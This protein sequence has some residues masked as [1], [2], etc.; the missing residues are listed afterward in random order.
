MVK[1]FDDLEKIALGRAKK[2]RVLVAAAHDLHTLEGIRDASAKG[3]VDPILIGDAARIRE[4]ISE[5]GLAL[6]HAAIID[7]KDDSACARIAA[8][9]VSNGAGDV[10]M[11]GKLQTP[12]L[13]RE[14]VNKAYGLMQGEI[15]SHVGLFS[16][17]AYHKLF[18]LTDG[19]M[20]IAPDAEE[21]RKI[22]ANAVQ[23]LAL[24]GMTNPKV[25]ALCATETLNPKMAA[26]VDAALLK[27]Q[28]QEGVIADCVV[29]GPI[30]FDLAFDAK[31]ARTKGFESPVA[32]DADILLVPDMTAGNLVAKTFMFAAKGMMAG[33]IVGA[34]IPIVLVSRGATAEE[35]YWSLVFA[36]AVS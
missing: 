14:I 35:K 27:Q 24:I 4:I 5:N 3:I 21:K 9:M 16:V 22:L 34:K 25:A 7:A 10:I 26:S 12:D 23:T 19:G 1:T 29:E 33:L 2:S 36:A 17:P 11:K 6:D 13:L 20:V 15:M 31:S 18:A 8:R 32:G 30:S 28:N